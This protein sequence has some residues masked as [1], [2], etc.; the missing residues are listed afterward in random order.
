MAS[1]RE[2]VVRSAANPRPDL[3]T[4]ALPGVGEMDMLRFDRR[5]G[6]RSRV[7]A[8]G[9]RTDETGFRSDPARMVVSWPA[10]AAA[11]RSRR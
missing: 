11:S 4:V 6:R 5:T 3:V 7:S 9:D 10:T 1:G 2:W 8:F